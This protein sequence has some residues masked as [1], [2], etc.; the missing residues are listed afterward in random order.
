MYLNLVLTICSVYRLLER[1]ERV[2]VKSSP[3]SNA[4][5]AEVFPALRSD[6]SATETYGLLIDLLPKEIFVLLQRQK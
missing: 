2:G 5:G 1:I 4:T 3:K 6:C